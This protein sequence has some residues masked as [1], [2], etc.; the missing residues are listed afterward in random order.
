MSPF[1]LRSGSPMAARDDRCPV[2]LKA[3]ARHDD[4]F[5]CVFGEL[6]HRDCTDLR[7]RA[8]RR[9]RPSLLDSVP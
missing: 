5:I 9:G 2:C 8:E 1:R 3:I 6:L 7:V 4:E